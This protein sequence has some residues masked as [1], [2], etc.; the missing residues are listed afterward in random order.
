MGNTSLAS[1][2]LIIIVHMIV[3]L[4]TENKSLLEAEQNYLMALLCIHKYYGDPRGRGAIG[5]KKKFFIILYFYNILK[6]L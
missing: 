6:K 2:D 4:V 1:P 3:G 5:V